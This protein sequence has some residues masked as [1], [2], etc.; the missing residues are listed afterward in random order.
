MTE[1]HGYLLVGAA[2]AIGGWWHGYPLLGLAWLAG[3]VYVV[4][5][6]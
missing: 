2:A 4:W 5:R 3:C 6:G 1:R